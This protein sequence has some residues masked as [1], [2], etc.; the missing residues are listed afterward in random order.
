VLTTVLTG[1][2]ISEVSSVHDDTSRKLAAI[3]VADIAEYSRLM[4]GNEE[5]TH[6]RVR[7]LQRELVGP[8]VAEHRSRLV[9][10]MG[11]GF[12]AMFD[13]PV[14]AVRCAIVLQQA[15][16]GRNRD[17]LK[18]QWIRYRIGVNLGDVIVDKGDVYGEGVNIAATL[19][20]L[21]EPGGVYISGGVYEQ[22]K[23][24]LVAGYQ[25]LGDRK[26]KNIAEPVPI[27]R[28][29]P[30]PTVFI[31][32][33][34]QQRWR[35]V[36]IAVGTLIVVSGVGGGWYAWHV[37]AEQEA[38]AANMQA[39]PRQADTMPSTPL[40]PS[41]T[42]PVTDQPDP[43][44]P[45]GGQ[46]A[47]PPQMPA[48]PQ[49]T[50]EQSIN[51]APAPELVNPDSQKSAPP[52]SLQQ[53]AIVPPT[54]FF[55]PRPTKPFFTEPEMVALPG[56]TFKMGSTDDPS[57]EPVH[58]VTVKPFLIGRYPVTR[59]EWGECVAANACPNV[60]TGRDNEPASN[61][62]WTDAQRY[63][64]WLSEMTGKDF[65]LPT[66]AEW[67]YAAR[68]GTETPYW[69][70]NRMAPR[71]ADC[72]DC[73]GSHEPQRPLA[74]GSSQPNP[75]GI[76]DVAGGV[77]QWVADC[78]HKD[79]HGAPPD[80][81]AWEAP[82]CRAHVLRGGSWRNDAADVRVSSRESYDTAV[83]YPGHGLRVARSE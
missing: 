8:T 54:S 23:Y 70:G 17:L 49:A 1:Y 14:E 47:A 4:S 74:V 58:R 37:Q 41:P 79:Y 65:R 7:D 55:A 38:P 12:L 10:T 39:L 21:A 16:V 40:L 6:R 59:K 57:E 20:Q 53:A 62:S 42:E 61:V 46:T 69:W 82:D 45:P 68:A 63:A 51:A 34:R 26:V 29:L 13:S 76:Y 64:A 60:S 9:K 66:E 71:M 32:A 36:A 2:R 5:A 78:W 44:T 43:G 30:D 72:N 11:D 56:G 22:I 80:G 77:A 35:K 67:E 19:Q 24:K 27:Y 48:S 3:L 31:R 18:P 81:S 75:F 50:A 73:G 25:S 52:G 28:V 15:M 33:T 83:R